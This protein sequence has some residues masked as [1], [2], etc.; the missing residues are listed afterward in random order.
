MKRDLEFALDEVPASAALRSPAAWACL[1]A[2]A[3]ILAVHWKTAASIVAIWIRSETFTHGFLV[4]PICLWLAWRQRRELTQASAQPWWPGLAFVALAGALWL[5]ASAA[6]ALGAGQ[7]ALAFMLQAAIVTIVGLRMARVLAFPIAFLLFA[8]PFGEIFIPTMIDW[9]ADFTVAALRASGVPVFREVNLFVIPTGSWSVVE[10]CSGVRYV[11]ASLMVGTLFAATAYRSWQ[12]RVAFLAAS[13]LV[14]VVANWLRA[15]LIVMLGHLSNNRL[16]VGVD[17]II[18][19]WIFFGVVML[20][21]F[22]VG[23]FWR[24]DTRDVHE[25]IGPKAE[26]IAKIARP[27]APFLVAA[28][29][30]VVVAAVW[31]LLAGAIDRSSATAAPTLPAIDGAGGWA[32][33]ATPLTDWTPKYSGQAAALAQTFANGERKAGI[34]VEYYRAQQRGREL[35][36]SGNMLV[37][38]EDNRWKE[39][40]SGE[41]TID[42]AGVSK[43]ARRVTLTGPDARLEVLSLYWVDGRITASPYVGKVLQAWSRLRGNGDDAALVVMYA[44]GH[45]RGD[46]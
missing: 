23:S 28:V 22:W 41:T 18:Y 12:R 32:Q 21:L 16:A 8:V 17:H 25:G 38:P 19:G 24:E 13:V 11:I 5:V 29:A 2:V 6:D 44:A 46:G 37:A 10:A 36:T 39:A 42:W 20:L 45:A 40:A 35:I 14:P 26:A 1:L 43:T 9:T 30:A 33:S 4:V 31:P 15:Y 7:F 34:F 3:G 27:A